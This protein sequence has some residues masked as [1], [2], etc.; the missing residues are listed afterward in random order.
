MRGRFEAAVEAVPALED[1]R[2]PIESVLRA[3][4]RGQWPPLQ[5]IHGDYH[6]GQ[7]LDVPGRGWV[8]LDFE[9]EPLR[10][11]AERSQPDLALRDVAGMLRSFDYA[12]HMALQRTAKHAAELEALAP[13]ARRWERRVRSHW[14]QAYAEVAMAG[15]LYADTAAFA[16]MDP[17]LGLFEL[18]KALYELRYEV[19]NRPDWVEVPLAGIA[20]LAGID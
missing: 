17:L 7:V 18:E 1:V 10:P 8:L 20:A 12:R 11:L 4:A 14:L 15:G 13:L 3:A 16:A 9:G 6:L 19:D 5:R 2:G